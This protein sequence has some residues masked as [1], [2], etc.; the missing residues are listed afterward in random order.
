M[1]YV[2]SANRIVMVDV[3]TPTQPTYIGEFSDSVLNGT[4]DRCVINTTVTDPYLVVIIGA[5]TSAESFA[6][7]GLSNPQSPNLL[8]IA[9][10]TYANMVDL[11]FAGPYAFVTTSYISYYQNNGDIFAQNGDLV[12]FNFTNPAAPLFLGI[13]QPSGIAGI[14]RSEPEAFRGSDQSAL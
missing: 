2:C 6:I 5:S 11:S 4:G 10:T 13:L 12:A 3:T 9:S 14:R 1:A 8:D 7:Y